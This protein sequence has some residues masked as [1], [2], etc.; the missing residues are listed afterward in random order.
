MRGAYDE[1]E[2]EI[3]FLSFDENLK[4]VQFGIVE[5]EILSAR[6]APSIFLFNFLLHIFPFF[7]GASYM[8][9]RGVHINIRYNFKDYW[10]IY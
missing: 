4:P 6:G 8:K 3:Y 1:I 10:S 9:R 5:K 2:E 7:K